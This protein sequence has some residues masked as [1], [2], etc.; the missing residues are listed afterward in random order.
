MSA[1]QKL[2][3]RW[4]IW[5]SNPGRGKFVASPKSYRP[6]LWPTEP[7]AEWVLESFPG[8]KAARA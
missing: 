4:M 8:D 3:T 7:P 1:V 2:A 6:T 5:G